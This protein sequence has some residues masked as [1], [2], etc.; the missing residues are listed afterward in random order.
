MTKKLWGERFE[1]GLAPSAIKLSYSVHSDKRLVQYDIRVNQAH[2]KALEKA[3]IFTSEESQSVQNCL[4]QLSHDFQNGADLANLLVDTDED[5]HSCIERL[6]TDRLGDLGKKLHT[7]K[8][9]NDQVIT[10]SRLFIKDQCQTVQSLLIQLN[11][12][13]IQLAT[14]YQSVIFPGFTHFQPAQPVLFAHHILAYI[15]MFGRDLTR[16]KAAFETA[17]VCPLGSAALAGN[18]YGLDRELVTKELGFSKL[19]QNSMDAVAD[20]DFIL[21]FVAAS[22]FC[23]THLSRFCEEII[24]WNSPIMNFIQLGDDFTTGSSIMPQK[25]NPDMA[26]L[27]RGKSGRIL[28]HL[29]G[30]QHTLKGLPLTYNRDLQEDKEVMFDTAD[31][32]IE[33]LTC[34]SEMV[35]TMTLNEDTIRA[36]LETGYLT[37]TE[38]ADYLARKGVPF[39]QSHEITGKVV[40]YAIKNSKK[41]DELT[42][43]EFC[44]F[45]T[46][47]DKDVYDAITV[48]AAIASK[49][50]VGGTAK[51][52][53]AAQLKRV[54]K[55]YL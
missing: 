16:F 36:S 23:M 49:N 42:Q 50:G 14:R 54:S 3:G 13:L 33:S 11:Q 10:D 19:T 8:S 31:T 35:A 7:G 53:V 24:I 47:V 30:L 52:Q 2:A 25:K 22:S 1:K 32:I 39:R 6:V 26:E 41:L 5:I 27:I 9:R 46:H 21:E 15:E 48:E 28:G 20:R 18:S 17:D 40:N 51:E 12:A 38:F 37:A 45:S 34:F 44:Q 55:H 43:E 4:T 29:T